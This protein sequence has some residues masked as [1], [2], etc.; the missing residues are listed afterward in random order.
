MKIP[1]FWHTTC[2]YLLTK[3]CFQICCF[4]SK[5]CGDNVP[6][7][8]LQTF[9]YT[10]LMLGIGKTGRKGKKREVNESMNDKKD[11]LLFH[12]VWMYSD[13]WCHVIVTIFSCWATQGENVVLFKAGGLWKKAFACQKGSKP[14]SRAFPA[15]YLTRSKASFDTFNSLCKCNLRSYARANKNSPLI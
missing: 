11:I 13:I 1:S 14:G 3:I 15:I 9:V 4:K 10:L 7:L 2:P 6:K 5:T 8:V 12:I